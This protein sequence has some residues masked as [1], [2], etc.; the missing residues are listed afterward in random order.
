[1]FEKVILLM[2][3]I[4]SWFTLFMF[5]INKGDKRQLYRKGF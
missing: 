2:F 1:M 4:I 3:F 5:I